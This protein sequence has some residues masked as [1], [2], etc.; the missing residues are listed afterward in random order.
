MLRF[1]L[2]QWFRVSDLTLKEALFEVSLCGN[3]A[4]LGSTERIPDRESI[5]RF[6]LLLEEDAL[7]QQSSRRRSRD[8]GGERPDAQE[9]HDG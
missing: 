4:G 5:L 7:A 9:R 8:A 1:H 3:F 2:Q 6:R